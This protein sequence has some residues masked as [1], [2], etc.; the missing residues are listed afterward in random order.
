MDK[1]IIF[2]DLLKKKKRIRQLYKLQQIRAYK[3]TLSIVGP[4]NPPNPPGVLGNLCLFL[5]PLKFHFFGFDDFFLTLR[6]CLVQQREDRVT[7]FGTIWL[8]TNCLV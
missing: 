1:S 3:T 4:Q 7:P 5:S 8:H 2:I 6:L